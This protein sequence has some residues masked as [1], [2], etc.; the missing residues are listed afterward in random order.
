MESLRYQIINTGFI[1]DSAWTRQYR[2]SNAPSTQASSPL[3]F[4]QIDQVVFADNTAPGAKTP[5]QLY[6]Q[7][8]AAAGLPGP[9][10]GLT[11]FSRS[12]PSFNFFMV[13]GDP[14][15]QQILVV[16]DPINNLL[17][18]HRV[19]PDGSLAPLWEKNAYKV[20]ASPA[21][22]PDRDLLYVDDHRDGKDHLV[23]LKLSTGQ[24]L[25]S[26]PLAA[27]LPTIGTIFLGMNNDVYILSSEAGGKNGLISRIYVP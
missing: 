10:K 13:A 20:S 1:L 18:A 7:P 6:T 21:L 2:A 9:L 19:K 3:L 17:A 23:I 24:E 5:I 22:V 11:A 15:Q 25:A 14:Y 12:L 16:Y 27:T 26:I 8:T 4:G